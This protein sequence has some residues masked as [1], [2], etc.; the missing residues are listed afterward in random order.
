MANILIQCTVW[1][2]VITV[3]L[4][5]SKRVVWSLGNFRECYREEKQNAEDNLKRSFEEETCIWRQ[6]KYCSAF[7]FA[8]RRFGFRYGRRVV[9]LGLHIG[10]G[11]EAGNN[12]VA[13]QRGD[14]H[15]QELCIN[16]NPTL[17]PFFVR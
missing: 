15:A 4:T 5:A 9:A 11:K 13:Y 6:R 7:L 14:S 3:E 2:E 12:D 8:A 17:Y 1:Y 16:N 10:R